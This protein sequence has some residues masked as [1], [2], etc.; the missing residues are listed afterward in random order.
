MSAE[1]PRSPRVPY[2]AVAD[3]RQTSMPADCLCLLVAV[4]SLVHKDCLANDDL[5]AFAGTADLVLSTSVTRKVFE[6]CS[7]CICM[8]PSVRSAAACPNL[9]SIGA[10]RGV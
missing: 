7:E 1:T 5:A 3:A 9:V 8:V 4:A 6:S 10:G 2:S